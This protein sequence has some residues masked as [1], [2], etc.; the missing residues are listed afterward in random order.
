MGVGTALFLFFLFGMIIIF[1]S[2]YLLAPLDIWR[3]IWSKNVVTR[4]FGFGAAYRLLKLFSWF[5]VN[6]FLIYCIIEVIPDGHWIG[7]FALFF[8]FF[9]LFFPSLYEKPIFKFLNKFYS[10][11]EMEEGVYLMGIGRSDKKKERRTKLI[12]KMR[13]KV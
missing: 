5:F 7:V 3:S 12:N 8:L 10:L 6:V 13:S 4:G 9:S 11:D 1:I 2:D